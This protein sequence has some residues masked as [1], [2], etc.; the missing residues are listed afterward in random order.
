MTSSYLHVSDNKLGAVMQR[1]DHREE[2]DS[3]SFRE[4]GV[5]LRT[6][7]RVA[8]SYISQ[9]FPESMVTAPQANPAIF[10]TPGAAPIIVP[11]H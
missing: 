6:S 11:K 8:R 2:F 3:G 5:L 7:D 1:N 10:E 9:H 4:Y